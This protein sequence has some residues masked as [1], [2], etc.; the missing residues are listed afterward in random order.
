MTRFSEH[1]EA[2]IWRLVPSFGEEF[3]HVIEYH[4][5][6]VIKIFLPIRSRDSLFITPNDSG[7]QLEFALTQG[8]RF[9]K[10]N[11]WA[12]RS[13]VLD[14]RPSCGS[15][16]LAS[17]VHWGQKIATVNPAHVQ[18]LSRPQ[19]LVIEGSFGKDQV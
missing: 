15:V 4:W 14:G 17:F 9:K 19:M 3:P 16:R 18:G 5:V 7:I 2:E 8:Y 12:S 6:I 10:Q 1:F 11:S 13:F